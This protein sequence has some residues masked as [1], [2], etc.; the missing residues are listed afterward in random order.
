MIPYGRQDITDDDIKAVIDTLNSDF[1]TQGPKI[2][3]FENAISK[4]I[5]SNHSVLVNS[6]TSALHLACLALDLG[7]GDILWTSANSFVASSNCGLY[8]GADVSFVDIDLKTY[9]ICT[10]ILE[11]KLIEAKK[12]KCLPKILVVV[13]L[14]GQSCDMKTIKK[15][16]DEYGFKIIEDASH[17]VGGKY[18]DNYIGCCE[19]SD[20]SVFSFH[21]VKII[22]TAEGGAALTN[23]KDLFTKM[24]LLRTHGITRNEELMQNTI[25]GPWYYEQIYLGLNY[26][27]TDIQAALGLSQFNRLDKYVAKRNELAIKYDKYLEELP[28]KTPEIQ[29]FNYSSFHL[30]VILLD[31][32][33]ISK[34]K[35]EVFN[36]LRSKEIG[37]NLHYIPIP[38][39]P[40][41]RNLGFNYKDYPN[42]YEYYEKA[43]SIPMFPNLSE[44]NQLF[45]VNTLK[46]I[47]Q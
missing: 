28:I 29:S 35:K 36:Y 2:D 27:I 26:R 11:Q 47:L 3:E 45:V 31:L 32:D 4:K 33:N 41:Y 24:S 1:I 37:V 6:A 7:E 12:N 15:L 39:H 5:G 16:S 21:P 42:S 19:Y 20:I 44:Q 25:D 34:T 17:A 30:Y 8:C 38:M 13:H 23:D 18:H 46:E 10:E 14:C 40:F 22:T 9:N 43:I